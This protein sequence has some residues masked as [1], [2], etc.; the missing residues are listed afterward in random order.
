MVGLA[1]LCSPQDDRTKDSSCQST[2]WAR[3]G[4]WRAS[5]PPRGPWASCLLEWSTCRERVAVAEWASFASLCTG[6]ARH[7]V[8]AI[9]NQPRPASPGLGAAPRNGKFSSRVQLSSPKRHLISAA[10]G[11]P[12]LPQGW[13]EEG[14]EEGDE[15]S[16]PSTWVTKIQWFVVQVATLYFRRKYGRDR[17][18]YFVVDNEYFTYLPT[19]PLLFLAHSRHFCAKYNGKSNTRP[20]AGLAK[21]WWHSAN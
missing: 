15:R 3:A 10:A 19:N 12:E 9:K 16:K 20:A 7:A 2:S 18:N 5:N 8:A 13:R 14:M 6:P 21:H 11:R 1:W 17:H 4:G